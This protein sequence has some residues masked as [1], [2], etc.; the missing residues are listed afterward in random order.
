MEQNKLIF[1][2]KY[3]RKG[4]DVTAWGDLNPQPAPGVELLL[5]AGL[6]L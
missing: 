2:I 5:T 1:P 4:D 3:S 6:T